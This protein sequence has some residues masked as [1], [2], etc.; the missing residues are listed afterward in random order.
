MSN[1]K[2]L[3]VLRHGKSSWDDS[4]KSDFDRSLVA[5]GITDTIIMAKSGHDELS[6]I[7]S[8]ISSPACRAVHSAVTFCR[9]IGLPVNKISLNADLYE[10]TAHV[11][12]DVVRGFDNSINS[13]LLVGHNPTFT[14]FVNIFLLQPID[15]LPTAGLVCIRFRAERWCEVLKS[16]L[17]TSWIDSPKNH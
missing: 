12:L 15:N 7:E 3:F 8:I 16:N 13:V 14:N 2:T 6:Q 11:V 10:T 5:R 17:L 1:I 9:A 4:E